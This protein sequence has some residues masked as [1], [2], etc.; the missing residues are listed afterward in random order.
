MAA[1]Y[2][3]AETYEIAF[4]YR[5]I[6]AEVNFVIDRFTELR[7]RPPVSAVELAAGPGDHAL[8]LAARGISTTA[9][10]LASAMC[11]RARSRAV[12][13]GVGLAVMCG[14]MTDFRLKSPVDLVLTVLDSCSHLLTL[15]AMVAH[16]RCVAGALT[17]G[18]VYI[19]ELS[20]PRDAFGDRTTAATWEQERE[21]QVV[22]MTWGLPDDPFDPVTLIGN[23]TVVVDAND[24]VTRD[25]VPARVWL[26]PEFEAAV[27]LAGRL[28]VVGW[29][30]GFSGGQP[31]TDHSAW[32]AIAV[33][34]KR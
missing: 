2:D 33:M 20:H 23:V 18:G 25:F 6:V 31:V 10:D 24:T 22:R 9:L 27:R 30:G 12:T 19:V 13:R 14:D 16:L 7:G 21:G 8:E 26:I 32:R 1:V 15:D 17:T 3:A 28:Q 5:D 11:A 29:Y 4:S 34:Q